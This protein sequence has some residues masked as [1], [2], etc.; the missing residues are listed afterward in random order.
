MN[1]RTN[2]PL[3]PSADA[4]KTFTRLAGMAKPTPFEPPPFEKIAVLMPI[5]APFM[6]MRPPPE[7]PGLMAASVWMK[8]PK[9]PDDT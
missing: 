8:K 2:E 6:S 4:T 5:N 7:L 9:S 3:P 1:G